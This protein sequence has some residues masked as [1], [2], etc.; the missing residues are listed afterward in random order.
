MFAIDTYSPERISIHS[1]EALLATLPQARPPGD[2]I[3]CGG[4]WRND[5][6]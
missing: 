6:E 4:K 5:R 3:D 1:N 2:E